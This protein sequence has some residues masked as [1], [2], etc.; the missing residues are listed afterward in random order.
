MRFNIFESPKEASVF[1][2]NIIAEQIKEKENTVLGLATGSTPI[3]TYQNL[4]EKNKNK[5]I[6]FEK[7][8]TVN[9]DEYVGLHGDHEQSYRYFMNTN[10]FDHIDIAK[11][12][13]H[14]PLGDAEDLEKMCKEYEKL[15]QDLGGIDLQVLGIG[16]NGHIAFNEPD[17]Q[18]YSETHVT[19]LTESTIEANKRFFESKDEVPRKAVTMGMS[20]ILR[21]KHIIVLAFGAS[22]ADVVKRLEDAYLDPQCPV[23]FLK[24]HENVDIIV[25]KEAASKLK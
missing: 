16:N 13:T 20:S 8:G 24:M 15:I 9:L 11:E 19:D 22:K 7:V 25:D 5:E 10:L 4:I 3:E 6:S 17:E 1:A 14:V 23:T 18:L 12:K 2:S 21:A